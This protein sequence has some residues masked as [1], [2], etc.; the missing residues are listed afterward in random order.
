MRIAMIT[1]TSLKNTALATTLC[2]ALAG[3]VTPGG[4]HPTGARIDP[5]SLR[6]ERSL[7]N[8]TLSPTAWPKKD[9]WIGFGDPQLSSLIDEAL[10]T[11][12]SLDEAQARAR[13]AEAAADSL[14]AARAPQAELDASVTGARLSGKDPIYPSYAIGTF[15]WSK[16]VTAGFSWDLDLWGGKRAAWE[17]AL[18]RS[19]AAELDAYAARIELSVNVARAYVS[20][21]YA[22]TQQ[23]VA[24]R[25]QQRTSQYLALTRRLVAG[26][27]G[28]PQ[29]EALAD[30][31]AA[32]AEQQKAQADRAII[33]AQTSLSVLL[34]QGPDRG[35][36][37]GRPGSLDLG[38]LALPDALPV[39]LI[40][41]R[42]DLVAARWR[43][44][45][46]A[47]D[48]K[49]A[50]TQF[51]PNISLSAMAGFVAVGG[52]TNVF[53]LPARTYAVAPALS[54]PIFDGG[55]LRANL[56]AANAGYD[57]A[58][59]RYNTLLIGALNQVSDLVSALASVRT[60]IALE[61][62]AEVD[63]RKSW[64]DAMAGYKGGV[65]GPLTPLISRQQLLLAEQQLAA[66]ES[67]QADLSIRL[68]DALGGGYGADASSGAMNQNTM[69]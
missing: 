4:L 30:S 20:L 12:P 9:W 28:T 60:Q 19:H 37:I 3:C 44:E 32:S 66:L 51:L 40:G 13:Q 58:V 38:Q 21:G 34:G 8:V 2:L 31:E 41:R 33:A 24:E 17:A 59:A 62:R 10:K 46:A 36:S 63:A 48:I 65:N 67:Q 52:S 69:R 7:A 29:Q 5:N 15:A 35:L 27:L 47:R 18:G 57:E 43:V 50:R 6:S 45:A 23:D 11:N 61:K 64:Q 39:D 68:I 14:N 53:Q 55:R 54:L 16:S 22:F 56:A 26:G 49:A 25:E 42:T 1:M